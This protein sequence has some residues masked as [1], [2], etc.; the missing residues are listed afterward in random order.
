VT[1][2]DNDVDCTAP[3]SCYDPSGAYGV[4]SV[5]RSSYEKAYNAHVGWDSATG[6]G[7][8]NVEKLVDHWQFA[9]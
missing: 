8:L 9:P 2:G 7:T 6:I 5:K 3:N 4:L 1:L